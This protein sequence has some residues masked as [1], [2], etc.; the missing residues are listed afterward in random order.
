MEDTSKLCTQEMSLLST[1][2]RVSIN[3]SVQVTSEH[4]LDETCLLDVLGAAVWKLD[5]IIQ[6]VV[7]DPEDQLVHTFATSLNRSVLLVLFSSWESANSDPVVALRAE[8]LASEAER[9][10][11]T[12]DCQSLQYQNALVKEEQCEKKRNDN[13]LCASACL[14]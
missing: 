4:V 2:G 8:D 12:H 10:S 14:P 13:R 7:G 6:Q 11:S 9:L 1:E 5:P 3:I